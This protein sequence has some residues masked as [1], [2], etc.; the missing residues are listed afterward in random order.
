MERQKIR[1]EKLAELNSE[2][3]E[4]KKNPIIGYIFERTK[5]SDKENADSI[6]ENFYVKD[7]ELKEQKIS[8]KFVG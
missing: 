2:L 3:D 7:G 5:F 1:Q 4:L 6:E 8:Y